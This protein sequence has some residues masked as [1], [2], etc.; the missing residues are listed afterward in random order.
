MN[1]ESRVIEI[2]KKEL[3]TDS[4]DVDST[5]QNTKGWDSQFFLVL[6]MSIEDEFNIIVPNEKLDKLVSVKNIS[7]LIENLLGV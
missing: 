4:I 7:E 1:I 3:L 5:Y 6:I 2:L